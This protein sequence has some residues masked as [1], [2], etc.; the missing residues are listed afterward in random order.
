MV[1]K[2][3]TIDWVP[4]NNRKKGGGGKGGVL[5]DETQLLRFS[6]K[7]IPYREKLDAKVVDK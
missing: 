3:G 7:T 4:A 6:S 5:R 2:W 1:Y